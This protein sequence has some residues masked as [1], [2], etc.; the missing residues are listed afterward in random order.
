LPTLVEKIA[1]FVADT[2]LRLSRLRL[3]WC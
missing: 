2:F 1:S 3:I